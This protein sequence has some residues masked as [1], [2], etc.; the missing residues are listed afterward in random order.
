MRS[1]LEQFEPFAANRVFE[2]CKTGDVAAWL[3]QIRDK[4]KL[5]FNELITAQGFANRQNGV[6]GSVRTVAILSSECPLWVKSRHCVVSGRCPLYPQK[7]TLVERAGMSALCQKR[8]YGWKAFTLTP[9]RKQPIR[10]DPRAV[11]E[12]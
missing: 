2:I 7:W 5:T 6:Q 1:I 11:A 12:A 8:S 10:S 9:A 3:R 4:S